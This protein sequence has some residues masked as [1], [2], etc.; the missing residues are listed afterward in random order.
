M[1]CLLSWDVYE[2]HSDAN[3]AIAGSVVIIVLTCELLM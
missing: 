3:Y 1:K 2:V